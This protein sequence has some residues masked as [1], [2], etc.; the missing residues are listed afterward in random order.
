[1]GDRQPPNITAGVMQRED[2]AVESANQRRRLIAFDA[3]LS[4]S[5]VLVVTDI[6]GERKTWRRRA[7]R[8]W[9]NRR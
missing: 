4:V 7:R 9:H 8:L 6:G 1:M 2:E 3:K 5:R